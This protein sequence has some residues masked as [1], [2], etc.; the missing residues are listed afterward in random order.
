MPYMRAAGPDA[1]DVFVSV[2]EF[3]FVDEFLDVLLLGAGTD[4]Q[5]VVGIHDDILLQAADD[6]HLVLG[7]RNDAA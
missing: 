6:G 3:D 1:S 5:H 7:Q 4:H 2:V